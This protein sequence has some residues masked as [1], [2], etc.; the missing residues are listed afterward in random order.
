MRRGFFSFVNMTAKTFSYSHSEKLKSRKLLNKLFLEGKSLNAFPLKLIYLSN[1]KT[2]ELSVYTTDISNRNALHQ[3]N[4]STKQEPTIAA[5]VGVS[6][7]NFKKAV[8]RNRIKR[9]LRESYRLQKN[10]LAGLHKTNKQWQLF[11]MYTGKE[12]PELAVIHAKME[13]LVRKLVE[14]LLPTWDQESK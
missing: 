11:F 9:L 10:L 7:R 4:I 8:D 14:Q 6:S 12:L 2:S 3:S 13:L 5:G 1:E